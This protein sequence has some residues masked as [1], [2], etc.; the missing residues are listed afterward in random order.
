MAMASLTFMLPDDDGIELTISYEQDKRCIA[1]IELQAI[2]LSGESTD[3][4]EWL[5]ASAIAFIERRIKQT[6]DEAYLCRI[7]VE[8]EDA[9]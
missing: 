3:F 8:Y 4:S 9:A 6:L 7:A 1:G 2:C 5:S